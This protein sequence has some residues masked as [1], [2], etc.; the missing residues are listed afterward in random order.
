VLDS[1]LRRSPVLVDVIGLEV[2]M[3]PVL[4]NTKWR[5]LQ[6]AMYGLNSDSPKWRTRCIT[7]GYIS[8]WDGEWFYH[9]SEGGFTDIEWVELKIDSEEQRK[10]VL[11]ILQ[12]IHL[13]GEITEAGYKIYGYIKEGFSV[14]F[15]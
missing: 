12:A 11:P 14:D 8:D 15:L 13:P 3:Q 10:L 5:E 7:N 1:L 2:S 6:S 4:N 9:F